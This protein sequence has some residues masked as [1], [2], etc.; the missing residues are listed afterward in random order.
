MA[1]KTF[2]FKENLQTRREFC[3]CACKTGSL[4]ALTASFGHL[5]TACTENAGPEFDPFPGLPTVQGTRSGSTVTVNI[6]S[7]SPLATV[8]NAALVEYT[9]GALLVA[10]VSQ[11]SFTALT[12][13][14]THQGTLIN[15]Y[16]NQVYQCPNHGSQFNT[17]GQVVRG[18]AIAPL[19]SFPT[20][21]AN[22][23]LT[24]TVP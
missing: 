18:P 21:Y 11:D 7:D 1:K 13:V 22:N 15:Q 3:L 8:G 10:R 12:R 17:S 16:T 2:G 6:V 23:V 24:I 4:L 20:Q 5:F 14:C 9:G 19:S